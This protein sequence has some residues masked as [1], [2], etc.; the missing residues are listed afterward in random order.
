ME[1][2]LRQLHQVHAAYGP[3]CPPSI[4]SSLPS[5]RERLSDR[6]QFSRQASQSSQNIRDFARGLW[7]IAKSWQRL[8]GRS[9]RL[10]HLGLI[11]D[12]A[13]I[14]RFKNEEIVF[15]CATVFTP[16][17]PEPSDC[18]YVFVTSLWRS[19]HIVLA[20]H[21]PVL[22]L[23]LIIIRLNEGQERQNESRPARAC[24]YMRPE[25]MARPEG[26]SAQSLNPF[27]FPGNGYALGRVNIH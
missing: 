20:G 2:V 8:L 16:S 5:L 23:R 22:V 19:R 24:R 25:T 15:D 27:R 6:C 12:I 4:A 9:R 11:V 26:L 1:V 13:C 17:A 7:S 14:Y 21:V 10:E 3:V 18:L